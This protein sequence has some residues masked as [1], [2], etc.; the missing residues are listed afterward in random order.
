[1]FLTSDCLEVRNTFTTNADPIMPNRTRSGGCDDRHNMDVVS[2]QSMLRYKAK[3][4]SFVPNTDEVK[5]GKTSYYT[6]NAIA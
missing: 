6:D 1:M 5:P 2:R 3:V 4:F